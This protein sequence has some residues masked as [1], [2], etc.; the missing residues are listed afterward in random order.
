MV[1][2]AL[3]GFGIPQDIADEGAGS[4]TGRGR[5]QFRRLRWFG[6]RFRF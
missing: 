1:R 6:F 4:E 5:L 3:V 2:T